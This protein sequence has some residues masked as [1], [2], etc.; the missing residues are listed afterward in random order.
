MS[1]CYDVYPD[2]SALFRDDS[3]PIHGL[4]E[5]TKWL[6]VKI[7]SSTQPSWQIWTFTSVLHQGSSHGV[8]DA[9]CP[10]QFSKSTAH[11]Y[12]I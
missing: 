4:R 1:L 11:T 6:N 5:L 2:W 3:D 9:Q 8:M 10:V 12:L 7:I